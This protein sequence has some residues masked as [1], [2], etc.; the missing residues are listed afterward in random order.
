MGEASKASRWVLRGAIAVTAVVV[1]CGISDMTEGVFS[2]GDNTS[3]GGGPD[4]TTSSSSVDPPTSSSSAGGQGGQGQGGAGGATTTTTTTT[5]TSTGPGGG[6]LDCGN[7]LTCPLGMDSAC[8]WSA[9]QDQGQ[10]I[11]G[12]PDPAT[13]NT[14]PVNGGYRTR[15]ECQLPSDCAQGTV[16]CGD[17]VPLGNGS[18]YYANV[19]CVAQCPPED[20]ILCDPM[21]PSCPSG[22]NCIQSQILPPGYFICS[23]N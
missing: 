21:S 11:Q 8:C 10:C 20:R 6:T 12:P 2:G 9:F 19:G 7:G 1:G 13:C 22:F 3:G 4:A 16:C 14:A 23:Q 18:A 5:T 15:I 17:R